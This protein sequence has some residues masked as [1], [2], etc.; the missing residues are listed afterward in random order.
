MASDKCLL[1]TVI[2]AV[3]CFRVARWW[4]SESEEQ[5]K[6]REQYLLSHK[7]QGSGCAPQAPPAHHLFPFL[8][9]GLLSW[10]AVTMSWPRCPFPKVVL[11]P[12]D[13][14]QAGMLL[15]HHVQ[16]YL[17]FACLSMG[18][19]SAPGLQPDPL[20]PRASWPHSNYPQKCSPGSTQ[21]CVELLFST[22]MLPIIF[23]LPKVDSSPA[24]LLYTV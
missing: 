13:P 10:L 4:C 8:S 12:A 22:D 5:L 23:S 1:S 24:T 9:K 15:L 7:W 21:V 14:P 11:L 19:S 3:M 6:Q 2:C 20:P 18:T 16:A 17:F